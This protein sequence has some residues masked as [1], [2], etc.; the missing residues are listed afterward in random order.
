MVACPQ[1]RPIKLAGCCVA[2]SQSG[3]VGAAPLRLGLP[4][5]RWRT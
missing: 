4:A 1:L 3:F 5:L 2:I